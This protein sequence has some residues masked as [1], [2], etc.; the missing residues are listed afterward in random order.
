MVRYAHGGDGATLTDAVGNLLSWSGGVL[1]VATRRGLVDVDEA[2]LRGWQAGPAA[3]GRP[4]RRTPPS[5]TCSASPRSAGARSETARLGGWRLRAGAGFTGRAN[6]VLPLGDPGLPLDDAIAH[7]HA[8]VR[9]TRHPA[10]VPAAPA[11]HRSADRR[12]RRTGVEH[13]RCDGRHGRRRRRGPRVVPAAPTCPRSR[14]QPPHPT[15]GCPATTTAAASC[16]RTPSGVLTNHEGAGFACGGRGRRHRGHRPGDR[17]RAVAL[18]PGG[19]GRRV[20]AAPRPGAP[21][22][23]RR[24]P[25]GASRRRPPRTP[26]GHGDQPAG[27]CALRRPRLQAAPTSYHYSTPPT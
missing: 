26:A 2:S 10:P 11:D 27:P 3:P 4:G 9:A 25:V 16:R 15:A 8:V 1:Q 13:R 12:A 21:R 19:R 18:R 5:P 6:S 7:V 24:A 22:H 20:R 23:G 17:R 14:S